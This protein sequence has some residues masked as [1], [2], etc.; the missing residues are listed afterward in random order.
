[1]TGAPF[2]VPN[3]QCHSERSEMVREAQRLAESKDPFRAGAATGVSRR[4]PC[5]FKR[6]R[7]CGENSLT[8]RGD[9]QDARGPSTATCL[10]RSERQVFAQ[11]DN[12][13][14]DTLMV[15]RTTNDRG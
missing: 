12:F 15:G 7:E 11:D 4:S 5:A 13:V 8:R 6:G 2:L 10:S 9:D 1:V 3:T 14:D